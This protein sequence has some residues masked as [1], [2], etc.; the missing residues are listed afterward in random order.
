MKK[1]I[2]LTAIALTVGASASAQNVNPQT[3]QGGATPWQDT[4]TY[5]VALKLGD[6]NRVVSK[7]GEHAQLMKANAINRTAEQIVADA[8]LIKEDEQ[9]YEWLMQQIAVQMSRHQLAEEKAK[10]TKTAPL[11]K[12]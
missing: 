5:V 10:A 12:Q 3:T 2:I 4:A 11:T 7:V 9:L 1:I 8:K 6:L